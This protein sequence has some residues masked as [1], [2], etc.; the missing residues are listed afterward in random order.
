MLG[1]YIRL[2]DQDD[3]CRP[4]EKA[5]SNSVANQ[6]SL[7]DHYIASHPDLADQ[8]ALE[9]VDDGH[10]GF[11]FNRPGV[12]ALFAAVKRGEVNCIL[13]KDDCVILEL[14]TESP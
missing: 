4:G 8:Y 6:R 3:D 14:N 7:L 10:T 1:K 11:N 12:Q 2:S 13:V 5:E 9:F